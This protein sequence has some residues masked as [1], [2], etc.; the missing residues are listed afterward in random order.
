MTSN[1]DLWKNFLASKFNIGDK[2]K[3]NNITINY[4]GG[5][6]SYQFQFYVGKEVFETHYILSIEILEWIYD[7]KNKIK[8][9][10]SKEEL[11]II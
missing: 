1:H 4:G 3:I 6:N 2:S 11:F 9:S 5:N 8:T 7:E 10:S